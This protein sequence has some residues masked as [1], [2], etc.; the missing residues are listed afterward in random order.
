M[1]HKL[2]IIAMLLVMLLS[3]GCSVKKGVE[4]TDLVQDEVASITM[5]HAGNGVLYSTTDT[6]LINQFVSA[7]KSD[8]YYEGSPQGVVGNPTI[9]LYNADDKSIAKIV[10]E[11]KGAVC[12]NGKSYRLKSDIKGIYME[13]FYKE[14]LK[15]E[16]IIE[17]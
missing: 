5:R 7:M 4:F 15:D 12:I 11:G 10:F 2:L 8:D 13:S 17:G 3:V 16:N 6:E 9:N 1:R 14:F